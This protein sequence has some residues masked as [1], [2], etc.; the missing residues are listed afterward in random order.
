MVP[1][2]DY[3]KQGN[4]GGL[5]LKT[6]G[7][8]ETVPLITVDSLALENCHLIKIDVQGMEREVV[9]GTQQTVAR[10]RPMLYVEND[11]RNKSEALIGLLFEMGFRLYWHIP[12]LFNPKNFFGETRNIFDTTVNVNMLCVPME[13]ALEVRDMRPITSVQDWWKGQ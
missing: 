11:L 4:F 3:D 13:A 7:P 8:G 2:V 6:K 9:L 1:P 10:C 12:R 5:S